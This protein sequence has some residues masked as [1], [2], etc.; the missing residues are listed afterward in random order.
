[1]P[2]PIVHSPQ[3]HMKS[4]KWKNVLTPTGRKKEHLIGY[5]GGR[6]NKAY[7]YSTDRNAC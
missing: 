7:I 4:P 2:N 3:L 1:M 5:R 6:S